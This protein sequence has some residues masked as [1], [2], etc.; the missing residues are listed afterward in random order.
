MRKTITDLRIAE[1]R[2]PMGRD[3]SARHVFCAQPTPSRDHSYCPHHHAI[4][5]EPSVP[6]ETIEWSVAFFRQRVRC[7]ELFM[8]AKPEEAPEPVDEYLTRSNEP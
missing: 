4:A 3:A 2:W 5:Y 1:C 7:G 8:P 6:D